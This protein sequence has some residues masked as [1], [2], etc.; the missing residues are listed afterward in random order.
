MVPSR[1]AGNP[2]MAMNDKTSMTCERAREAISASIDNEQPGVDA[3]LIEAHLRHCSACRD[4]KSL[5]EITRR[6][7]ALGIAPEMPDLSR[8]ITKL[9]AI[10][11]RASK[12][13]TVRA[14]LAVVAIQIIIFSVPSLTAR[15][16][17]GAAAH[18]SR[19]L[20]AFTIAYAVALLVVV[21]RP[22]R[23]RTVFPVACVLAGALVITAAIDLANGNVPFLGE[24]QHL[25]EI[26][27]VGLVWAL[28]KPTGKPSVPRVRP[29]PPRL[30]VVED[31]REAS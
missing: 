20:G 16:E 23:A 9:A 8:R 14:L 1:W 3:R 10:A 27:S 18:D 4:Y 25:P 24:A 30:S 19:H 22:A 28:A 26:L 21:V 11:D 5:A 15:D 17:T 29:S 6:A 2:A 12:W 13:S 31:E 7:G